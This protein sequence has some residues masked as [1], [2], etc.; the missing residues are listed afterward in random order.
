MKLRNMFFIMSS[1]M[2]FMVTG[3]GDNLNANGPEGQ[4]F[5]LME[6][7]QQPERHFVINR[8][9]NGHSEQ[10]NRFGFSQETKETAYAGQSTPDI[11][12][13][14]R[15]LM[16]DTISK[17]VVTLRDINEAAALVT[18]QHVLIVYDADSDDETLTA[19]QVKKTAYSVVPGSYDVYVSNNTTLIQD[20]QRFQ[21]LS[22]RDPQYMKT[23]EATIE[24]FKKSPQ[25]VGIDLNDHMDN[26]FGEQG[27]D[28]VD[29]IN[30]GS[31]NRNNERQRGLETDNG[32]NPR[33]SNTG[34]RTNWPR[35]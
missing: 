5:D 32:N 19:T 16:A 14:D 24:D 13:F 11:A 28:D 23:L 25:G 8:E 31:N 20:I 26:D 18:D 29:Q 10:Y 1:C 9:A 27:Q 3:C 4:R 17:L 22:S 33:R 30:R 34:N 12:I 35:D 2:I 15:S 7:Y 6:G 21:G